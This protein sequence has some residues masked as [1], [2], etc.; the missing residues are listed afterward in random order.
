MSM[1][2]VLGI[3]TLIFSISCSESDLLVDG[4]FN[5]ELIYTSLKPV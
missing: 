2:K 5:N 4:K 3:V 1:R